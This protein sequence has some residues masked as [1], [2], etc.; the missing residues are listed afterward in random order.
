METLTERERQIEERL[1]V[2]RL[3]E[4]FPAVASLR[5]AL[6]EAVGVIQEAADTFTGLRLAID[7]D[8]LDPGAIDARND[9]QRTI[10]RLRDIAGRYA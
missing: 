9:L 6:A 7:A 10:D 3:A 1:L 8:P 5:D 2:E 4:R